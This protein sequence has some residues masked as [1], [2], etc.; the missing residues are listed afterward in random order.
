M[1]TEETEEKNDMSIKEFY[2]EMKNYKWTQE[3]IE[4]NTP[5][6]FIGKCGYAPEKN[7]Y[8]VFYPGGKNLPGG[9]MSRAH[10]GVYLEENGIVEDKLATYT[11]YEKWYKYSHYMGVDELIPESPFEPYIPVM[12]MDNTMAYVDEDGTI[13]V[14]TEDAAAE[15][16]RKMVDICRMAYVG[17]KYKKEGKLTPEGEKPAGFINLP[18]AKAE[19]EERESEDDFRAVI[20]V[21]KDYPTYIRHHSP[22][23]EDLPEPD[24]C[25]LPK[26]VEDEKDADYVRFMARDSYVKF[27]DE[28]QEWLEKKTEERKNNQRFQMDKMPPLKGGKKL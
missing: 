25:P 6:F 22:R 24:D 3:Q 23:W 8:T 18:E 9:K 19:L 12:E 11:S 10:V 15:G 28:L 4:K 1:K 21:Y 27:V 26:W 7:I 16:V 2:E 14:I 13:E 5:R 17:E 20:A